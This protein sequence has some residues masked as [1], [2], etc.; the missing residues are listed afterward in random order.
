MP[1]SDPPSSVD[2]NSES[3][4][5]VSDDASLNPMPMDGGI[6]SKPTWLHPTSLIFDLISHIRQLIFP[7]VIGLYS[8]SKGDKIGIYIGLA[9]SLIAILV[10]AFRYFTLRYKIDDGELIV[11][12]GLIFRRVRT[13]PINRIQNM[14]LLQ[15]PLHRLFNVAEVRVETASGTEPEA[16]LRVLSIKKFNEL[17]QQ[18]FDKNSGLASTTNDENSQDPA[19]DESGSTEPKALVQI[20][21]IWL[22]KAGLASNRGLVL[23]GIAIGALSQFRMEANIDL[24]QFRQWIPNF[25]GSLENSLKLL[26]IIIGILILLRILGMIWYWQRFHNYQ[27]SSDG[28]DFRISCGFFTKITATVP[29][30]RIQFISIHRPLLLRWM[31]LASIRIETAGGGGSA[32]QDQSNS[33]RWFV[34]V[35]PEPRVIP[36]ID[37]LR[38]ELNLETTELDWK[39]LAQR[40]SQRMIRL[41][42]IWSIIFTGIGGFFVPPWGWLAGVAALP[43]FVLWAVKK[44]RSIKYARTGEA[45]IYCSG[46]INQKTSLTFWDKVQTVSVTQ[47]PF[48]RRW[49]MGKLQ[50]DTAA[51]GP[52][53]HSIHVKYLDAAFANR[54]Y[55]TISHKAGQFE[56]DFG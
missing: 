23:V 15:N 2:P 44:S 46:I 22:I 10:S 56:P 53:E 36:L 35:L 47:S 51:A 19:S 20:P 48:D 43:L 52:A 11:K 9:V 8:A 49:G 24:N 28:D 30:N 25:D 31:G 45:M 17:Q 26:G 55:K 29:R 13:V 33:R 7:V 6:T 32:G 3:L 14:D 38:S 16:V 21:S 41:A 42:I 39:P 1:P 5:E 18:I 54:E 12:K 50:I 37:Q 4:T 27:L 40:A 34:P